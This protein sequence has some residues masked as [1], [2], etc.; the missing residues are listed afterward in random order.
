[1]VYIH[2]WVVAVRC[3]NDCS[4]H[5]QC[6]SMREI[7]QL[8]YGVPLVSIKVAK[9]SVEYGYDEDIAWDAD[10]VHGC[11]C[12]SSWSVGLGST[13]TQLAEY[14][15]ADCSMSMY[16][17]QCTNHHVCSRLSH[18]L[19]HR[20]MPLWRQPHHSPRGDGLCGEAADSG[21]DRLRRGRKQVPCGLF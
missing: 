16:H 13:D 20:T 5:G 1:M 9:K 10:I 4:G 12:D 7:A 14:F 6:L 17:I 19:I 11:V 3:P 8:D 21:R 2:T 15:G 18:L